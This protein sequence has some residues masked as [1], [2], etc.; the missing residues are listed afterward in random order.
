[1]SA[2]ATPPSSL[3]VN[4]VGLEL[5]LPYNIDSGVWFKTVSIDEVRIVALDN[6]EEASSLPGTPLEV[7]TGG[8]LAVSVNPTTSFPS[9]A[10]VTASGRLKLEIMINQNEASFIPLPCP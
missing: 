9:L 2:A 6:E 8:T 1:M 5:E 3:K 4:L 7:G 10:S